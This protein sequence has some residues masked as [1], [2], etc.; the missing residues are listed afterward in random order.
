MHDC[1]SCDCENKGKGNFDWVD[2]T[3]CMLPGALLGVLMQPGTRR[4]AADTWDRLCSAVR[5]DLWPNSVTDEWRWAIVRTSDGVSCAGPVR[6][7]DRDV[8]HALLLDVDGVLHETLLRGHAV[9]SVQLADEAFVRRWFV[10]KSARTDLYGCDGFTPS[11]IHKDLCHTCANSGEEHLRHVA[12]KI[13]FLL[14]GK[15]R[16]GLG[17]TD[18]IVEIHDGTITAVLV[19]AIHAPISPEEWKRAADEGLPMG[20]FPHPEPAPSA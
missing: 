10:A 15:A 8:V 16:R 1:K 2:A 18:I 5:G 7:A 14:L 3:L 4:A 12:K 9:T 20:P 17:R 11:P 13:L 6:R 19:K